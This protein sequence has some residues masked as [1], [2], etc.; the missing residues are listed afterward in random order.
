MHKGFDDPPKLAAGATTEE[1]KL[2]HY[3][4]MRDEIR[5][6]IMTL[7]EALSVGCGAGTALLTGMEHER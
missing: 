3:R 2:V 5:D 4:R 7:P 6:F 1:E